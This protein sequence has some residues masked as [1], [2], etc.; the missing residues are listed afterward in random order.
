MRLIVSINSTAHRMKLHLTEM[1][2]L[3]SPKGKKVTCEAILRK[4]CTAIPYIADT[5]GRQ[6]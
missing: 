3:N 4:Y 2:E 5:G 1:N 6:R